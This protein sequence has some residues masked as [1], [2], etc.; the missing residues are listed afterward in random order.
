M[1]FDFVAFTSGTAF[2]L[3]GLAA[4]NGQPNGAPRALSFRA[5]CDSSS[6]SSSGSPSLSEQSSPGSTPAPTPS[7]RGSSATGHSRGLGRRPGDPLRTGAARRDIADYAAKNRPG[8]QLV[9]E[10]PDQRR[11]TVMELVGDG[12]I[13]R[14]TRTTCLAWHL[15]LPPERELHGLTNAD[16]ELLE[17]ATILHDIGFYIAGS[18]HHRHAHYLITAIR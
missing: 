6:A 9:D 11:R 13:S 16:S 8:I 3:A 7:Y 15:D 12:T 2:A 10:F 14:C 4:R 5:L 18:R 1:G 17:F